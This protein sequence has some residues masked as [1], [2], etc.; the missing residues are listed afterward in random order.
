MT[1]VGMAFY[2]P[3]GMGYSL[4]QGGGKSAVICMAVLLSLSVIALL[5][6][7]VNDILPEP[8]TFKLACRYRQRIW[9]LMGVTFAGIAFVITR[10]DRS[11]WTAGMYVLFGLRCAAVSFLDLYYEHRDSELPAD[12]EYGASA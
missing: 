3:Y 1:V 6:T 5:D 2:E 8:Y 4:M 7:V 11:Y 10:S 12:P 9:L